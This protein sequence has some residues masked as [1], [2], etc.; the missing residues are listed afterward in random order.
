MDAL[1]IKRP[2]RVGGTMYAKLGSVEFFGVVS[3]KKLAGAIVWNSA[4]KS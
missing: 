1:G 2:Y 4:G 3:L